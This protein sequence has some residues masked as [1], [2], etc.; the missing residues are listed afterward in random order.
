[1]TDD[2]FANRWGVDGLTRAIIAQGGARNLANTHFGLFDLGADFFRSAGAKGAFLDALKASAK[3]VAVSQSFFGCRVCGFFVNSTAPK[4]LVCG[5]D[6]VFDFRTRARFE[7]RHDIDEQFL[8]GEEIGRLIDLFQGR[9][10]ANALFEDP[11]CFEFNLRR[12]WW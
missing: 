9:S 7:K 11:S 1:M 5:G 4:K 12:Q 10:G 3:C 8:V 2:L 6:D